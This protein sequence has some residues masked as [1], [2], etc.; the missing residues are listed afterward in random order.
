MCV[1]HIYIYIGMHVCVCVCV[2]VRQKKGGEMLKYVEE[3]INQK[4]K[5]CL[6]QILLISITDFCKSSLTVDLKTFEIIVIS[7]LCAEAIE[8]SSL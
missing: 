8:Y 5:I 6:L 7:S 3:K 4:I 2:Y 1:F